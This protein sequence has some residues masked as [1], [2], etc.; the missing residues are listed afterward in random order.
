MKAPLKPGVFYQ[1]HSFAHTQT[2]FAPTS[3]A[4]PCSQ[5]HWL[6]DLKKTTHALQLSC[7]FLNSSHPPSRFHNLFSA[8]ES[9]YSYRLSS[10][11]NWPFSIA[12]QV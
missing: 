4:I 3:I 6:R 5:A 2:L 10:D 11:A 8:L 12:K 1:P 7:H 9:R